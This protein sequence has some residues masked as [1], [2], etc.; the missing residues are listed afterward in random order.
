MSGCSFRAL[1]GSVIAKYQAVI[2]NTQ[3]SIGVCEESNV[4]AELP[5]TALAE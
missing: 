2:V 3:T 5:E 4:A 1:D